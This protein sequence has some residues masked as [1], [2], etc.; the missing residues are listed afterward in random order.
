MEEREERVGKAQR[1][2]QNIM[3]NEMKKQIQRRITEILGE[4]PKNKRILLERE[5][6]LEKRLL[7]KEANEEIWKNGDKTRAERVQTPR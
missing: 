3:E 1:L 6:E 4:L 2:K 7:I 5:M